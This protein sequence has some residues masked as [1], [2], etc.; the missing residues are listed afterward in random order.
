MKVSELKSGYLV[1]HNDAML[2]IYNTLKEAQEH[3][4]YHNGN[5]PEWIILEI[6]IKNTVNNK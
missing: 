3:I 1:C 2:R 4:N 5:Y 6:T